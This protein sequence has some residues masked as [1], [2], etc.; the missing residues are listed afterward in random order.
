MLLALAWPCGLSWAAPAA[1]PSPGT[2]GGP[3]NAEQHARRAQ[4]RTAGIARLATRTHVGPGSVVADIGAGGGQDTW[5]WA[6]IVGPRGTV[7]ALEVTEK[8]VAA[9]ATE[10]HKRNLAQVRPVLGRDDDPAP[11]PNTADLAYLRLVYHHLSQPRPMLRGIW[12]ALKPGGYLVVIDRHRGTLRD[13]VPRAQR[14]D[15]HFWIAETTVVREARAE[16]FRF[17]ACADDCCELPEP[18]VLIF[19]RPSEPVPPGHDPDPFLPL[20]I[21][22]VTASLLPPAE[23]LRHPVFIALGQARQLMAPLLNRATGPGLEIVLE[24]WATEKH[25]RPPLPPGV[26]LPS[27]LTRDGDPQLDR[28][29]IDAV[30]FLD[31]YHLLFHGPT[32]LSKLRERLTVDGRVVVMDRRDEQPQS[33]REASHRRR[34]DPAVVK[35]EMAAAGFTLRFEA[36]RPAP[37]RFLLVFGK[38]DAGASLSR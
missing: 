6:D 21:E 5:R 1:P 24:E 3:R 4:Q 20:A 26:A 12:H 11:P 23:R 28:R 22:R 37:D 8:Q 15:K 35:R 32:L 29:P 16:G 9:L 31:T 38:A 30:F 2:P 33:R 34:I 18:F 17:V 14:K 19:Q 10:A 36:P 13:W 25:E 27:V 7:Y